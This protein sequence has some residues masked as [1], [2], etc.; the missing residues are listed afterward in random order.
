VISQLFYSMAVRSNSESVFSIGLLS[1]KYLAAS[2]A[3]G[4]L[5]QLIVIGVPFMQRAFNLQMLDAKGWI[6]ALFLGLIPLV[7]NELYK[8]YF[9][10]IRKKR[11]LLF[12]LPDKA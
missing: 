4:V 8:V 10:S 6:M 7:A 12:G 3:L 1:N 2:I 5:L 11:L 9:R